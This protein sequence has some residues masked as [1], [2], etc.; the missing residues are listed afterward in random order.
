MKS[1]RS[2]I[3]R[4][5]RALGTARCEVLWPLVVLS[6]GFAVLALRQPLS[7]C[8]V[9]AWQWRRPAHRRYHAEQRLHLSVRSASSCWRAWTACNGP[10]AAVCNEA[11]RRMRWLERYCGERRTAVTALPLWFGRSV[12]LRLPPQWATTDTVPLS[13]V[14]WWL[15]VEPVQVRI[16]T[17]AFGARNEADAAPGVLPWSMR[18][19][20]RTETS[21]TAESL[22]VIDRVELHVPPVVEDEQFVAQVRM[23]R[24]LNVSFENVGALDTLNEVPPWTRHRAGGGIPYWP[25]Q[26]SSG[27]RT[28]RGAGSVP[29]AN[30]LSARYMGSSWLLLVVFWVYVRLQRTHSTSSPGARTA[31][32]FH[33]EAGDSTTAAST[34]RVR[35]K[36]GSPVPDIERGSRAH[37]HDQSSAVEFGCSR[38]SPPPMNTAASGST[39]SV[40]ARR[41]ALLHVVTHE[42]VTSVIGAG[43]M[44][45]PPS[46]CVKIVAVDTIVC[47]VASLVAGAVVS[48][49]AAVPIDATA[50]S[51]TLAVL[52]PHQDTA[53]L[54]ALRKRST[55]I[56]SG[57][58]PTSAAHN[59]EPTA[60]RHR[61]RSVWMERLRH[62]IKAVDAARKRIR[63][64]TAWATARALRY[65]GAGRWTGRLVQRGSARLDRCGPCVDRL[66]QAAGQA[67][68]LVAPR[69]LWRGLAWYAVPRLV[70]TVLFGPSGVSQRS[71]ALLAAALALLQLLAGSTGAAAGALCRR[72]LPGRMRPVRR[73]PSSPLLLA[74]AA[75]L[76]STDLLAQPMHWARIL[77]HRALPPF[78]ITIRLPSPCAGDLLDRLPTADVAAA[79]QI[80]LI[81]LHATQ[82]LCWYGLYGLLMLL[83]VCWATHRTP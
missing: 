77:P 73:I 35:R 30:R 46:A 39:P 40:A 19:L 28:T 55:G 15:D 75:L 14:Q 36:T 31:V 53:G 27:P 79:S 69:W 38:Q 74:A 54:D 12:R 56:L 41:F 80:A 24:V 4:W 82:W 32:P 62:T 16:S 10:D 52:E 42:A 50:G 6:I 37:G 2:E 22:H 67:C 3:G 51:Y 76:A 13:E 44:L 33:G 29:R 48:A 26:L 78:S 60:S 47:L 34:D 66:L 63:C 61:R 64:A 5:W 20:Y 7:S 81:A 25:R 21:G 1:G 58:R 57:D 59:I 23:P 71:L 17:A 49:T 8:Q 43:G 83:G 68:T 45:C 11:V 18:V 9:E 70:A 72:H 65:T